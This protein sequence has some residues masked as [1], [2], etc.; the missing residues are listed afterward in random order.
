MSTARTFWRLLGKMGLKNLANF[1][2]SRQ[3]WL[4][5][6]ELPIRTIIDVGA[7]EGQFA[8]KARSAFPDAQVHCFEPIPDLCRKI[9]SWAAKQNGRVQVHN[10]ALS[11][12]KTTAEF[13]I[14][15]RDSIASSLLS[16]DQD[17]AHEYHTISVAVDTLDNVADEIDWR[18]V[19]LL[20]IDTEGFDLEVLRG[21]R[22]SLARISAVIVE[23]IFFPSPYGQD[24]P[25]FEDISRELFDKGFVYRG[26]LRGHWHEGICYGLDAVFCSRKTAKKITD[27]N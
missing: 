14:N 2:L 23:S 10:L 11:S 8:R 22:Q 12:G 21:A 3:R 27:S 16:P 1:A 17:R 9:E 15:D 26:N 7:N 6:R 19:A 13:H 18:Q 24:A 20:K 5:L 25:L 4:G